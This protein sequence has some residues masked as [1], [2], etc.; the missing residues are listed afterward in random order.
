MIVALTPVNHVLE[1][2]APESANGETC[3]LI[4]RWGAQHAGRSA[5]GVAATLA[6]LWAIL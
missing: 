3:A 4:V 6:D 5:L 1:A 2:T